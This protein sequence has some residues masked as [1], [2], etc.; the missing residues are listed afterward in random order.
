M[1]RAVRMLVSQREI[2]YTHRRGKVGMTLVEILVVIAIIAALASIIYPA[3]MDSLKK[4]QAAMIAQRLDAVQKAEVQYSID[5][6]TNGSALPNNGDPVT[7]LQVQ[8]YLTR[9]GVQI[10]GKT[11]LDQGT[12][13]TVQLGTWGSNP[14]F[15]AASGVSSN[16]YISKYNIPT[17]PLP[18]GSP[19]EN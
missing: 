17:G 1:R 16:Q 12:G 10:Q 13:G 6:Q 5:Q 3:I 8:Q 9:F 11:D 15:S 2:A 4:S 19:G 14:Y 18:Q 7:F